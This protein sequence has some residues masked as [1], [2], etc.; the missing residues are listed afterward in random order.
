MEAQ[1]Y[2]VTV[3]DTKYETITFDVVIVEYDVHVYLKGTG[4]YTSGHG[5][6]TSIDACWDGLKGYAPDAEAI[7]AKAYSRAILNGFSK[8]LG[9]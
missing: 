7:A 3:T 4:K 6:C 8:L 9:L 5:R 2:I 1:E